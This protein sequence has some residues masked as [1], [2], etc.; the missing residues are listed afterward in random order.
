MKIGIVG[1][2]S[3]K[4]TLAGGLRAQKLISDLL[5]ETRGVVV[6]GHSPVGG[7][8]IWAEEIG[9]T[10]G[11]ELLIFPAK[12]NKWEGGYKQRNL[13]I[14]QNAD[15][16]HIIVADR[17]PEKFGGHRFPICYHCK[18]TDHVKSGGCWTG[19]KFEELHPGKK[20]VW[21]IVRNRDERDSEV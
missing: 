20:A 10:I 18:T 9:K 15:E 8:D 17:Y 3:D 12:E 19:K 6:S 5:Q 2:G 7:V 4:F 1:N 14:A 16:M 13:E 11:C 21:H